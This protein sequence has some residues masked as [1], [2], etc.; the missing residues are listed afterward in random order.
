M[1]NLF[2]FCIQLP[3]S[4]EP[5]SIEVMPIFMQIIAV[6]FNPAVRFDHVAMQ[7]PFI[8]IMLLCFPNLNSKAS[9]VDKRT[10]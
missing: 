10:E 4:L 6:K 5:N 2:K 3:G 7:K 8:I 9:D 1:L